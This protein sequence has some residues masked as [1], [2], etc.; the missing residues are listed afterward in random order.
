M[1]IYSFTLTPASGGSQS[2]AVIREADSDDDACEIASELL[3]E[4]NFSTIE[5][6]RGRRVV[7]RVSKVDP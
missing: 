7:Y 5:V 4:S 6:L 2:A 1:A 3:L